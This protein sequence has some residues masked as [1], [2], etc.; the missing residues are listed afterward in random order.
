MN[1]Y[2]KP[3][4]SV[5]DEIFDAD[6]PWDKRKKLA[7]AYREFFEGCDKR[8]RMALAVCLM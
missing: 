1:K 8:T 5:R 7:K 4:R 3:L 2:K 6:M